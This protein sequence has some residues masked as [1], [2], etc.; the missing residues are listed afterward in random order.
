ME[1]PLPSVEIDI[2]RLDDR[3]PKL[4]LIFDAA[5]VLRWRCGPAL[6]LFRRPAWPACPRIGNSTSATIEPA[7]QGVNQLVLSENTPLA[8]RSLSVSAPPG[9]DQI[10]R[11]PRQTAHEF[12]RPT[13]D[14][15][16]TVAQ[17]LL[18][19]NTAFPFGN[20]R[21]RRLEPH[22]IFKNSERLR[23]P[24]RGYPAPRSTGPCGQV[25]G[26]ARVLR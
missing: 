14:V 20:H 25:P 4:D 23:S 3:C 5:R 2:D 9:P 8:H 6:R 7:Q 17:A 15:R 21:Y 19:S 11:T 12:S 24:R 26:G 13:L 18:S 1:F 10:R 22:S 16:R